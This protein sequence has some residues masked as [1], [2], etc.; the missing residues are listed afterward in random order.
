VMQHGRSLATPEEATIKTI[1]FF[2]HKCV[3]I[4]FHKKVFPMPPY[5]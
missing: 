3:T 5:P 1:F 4:A 2:A